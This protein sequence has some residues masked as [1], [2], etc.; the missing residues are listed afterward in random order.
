MMSTKLTSR[1]TLLALAGL[2]AACAQPSAS[3]STPTPLSPAPAATSLPVTS[4]PSAAGVTFDLAQGQ[5]IG[6][7]Y[8]AFLSPMQEPGE[9]KDTPSLAPDAFRSTAPSLLRAERTSRG[10]G[11]VRFT[12]D[13]SRAYVDV[14]IENINP[15]DIVLFHIHCGRPDQLGPI[16]IDLAEAGGDLPT[17]FADNELSVTITN[18]NIEAVSHSEHDLV[19][20]FTAGCPLEVGLLPNEDMKTVASMAAEAQ[21]GLLYFNLHTKGQ[22]FFGDIRGQLYP[23]TTP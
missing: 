20:V 13:L 3:T 11:F 1:L 22:T 5:E 21:K 8:Q 15:A 14:K 19:G 16:M 10:Q 4:Q 9:E 7:V 23:V 18:A 2:F 17:Q 12:K 6:L